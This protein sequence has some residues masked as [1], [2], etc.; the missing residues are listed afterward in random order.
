LQVDTAPVEMDACYVRR[1]VTDVR[2]RLGERVK[3]RFAVTGSHL[4]QP[5]LRHRKTADL[6]R[7]FIGG[8]DL[9]T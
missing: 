4:Q 2:Q 5:E 9:P 1:Q 3:R 6:R 7:Y 8:D